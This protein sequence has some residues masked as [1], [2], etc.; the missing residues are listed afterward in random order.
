MLAEIRASQILDGVRGSRPVDKDAL[1]HLMLGVSR[2][3]TAFPEIAEL[4]L[5]PV[6]AYPEGLGVLDVRILLDPKAPSYSQEK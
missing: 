2:L 6:M 3:C 4:D 1:V 5:N